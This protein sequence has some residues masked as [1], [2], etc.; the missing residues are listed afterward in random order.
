MGT[1]SKFISDYKGLLNEAEQYFAQ[2]PEERQETKGSWLV[3]QAKRLL[4]RWLDNRMYAIWTIG[5]YTVGAWLCSKFGHS[6]KVTVEDFVSADRDEDG[7]IIDIH[8]G[9]ADWF[10]PRCGMGGRAWF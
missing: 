2:Y 8:G 1:L 7:K 9:G 4:P 6:S 10:C 3:S 5:R